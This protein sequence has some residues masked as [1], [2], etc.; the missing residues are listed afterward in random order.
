MVGMSVTSISFEREKQAVTLASKEAIKIHNE[1]VQIDPQLIFQRFSWIVTNESSEGS[2]LSIY[3]GPE[4]RH[5]N[6]LLL[7]V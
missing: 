2:L 5:L 3:H 4:E 1:Y 7:G 6:K